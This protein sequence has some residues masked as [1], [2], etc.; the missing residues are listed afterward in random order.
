VGRSSLRYTLSVTRVLAWP[1]RSEMSSIA[2]PVLDSS[3]TKL[4]RR[5][6]VVLD[7]HLAA[8]GS[9]PGHL[10][11]GTRHFDHARGGTTRPSSGLVIPADLPGARD[12]PKPYAGTA[13]IDR[14]AAASTLHWPRSRR[15]TCR[16]DY[17]SQA[18]RGRQ[19][20]HRKP[21]NGGHRV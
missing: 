20:H 2:S 10:L 9:D 3:E 21:R 14:T 19:R 16:K 5:L 17:P 12:E 11:G 8:A 13:A 6:G 18:P 7:A 15:R 1:T 4:C